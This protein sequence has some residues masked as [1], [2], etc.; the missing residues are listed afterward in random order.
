M[1]YGQRTGDGKEDIVTSKSGRGCTRHRVFGLC[2]RGLRPDRL[3]FK[4]SAKA[5][6][7]CSK[8]DAA[9]VS[10]WCSLA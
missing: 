4:T 1:A 3:G 10:E 5:D 9:S 7:K 6:S 2:Q 8:Q